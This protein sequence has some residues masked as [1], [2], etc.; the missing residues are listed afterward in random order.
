MKKVWDIYR[1]DWRRISRSSSAIFLIVALMILPSLYAWFNIKALWDPYGNTAGIKIAVANDDEGTTINNQ[2]INIGEQLVDMLKDNDSL[3]WTFVSKKEADDGVLYGDY[4]A[5]IYIPRDFTKNLSSILSDDLKK[6]E[7][8]YTY[9]DKINA[10][11]PKIT[12]KGAT[13]ITGEIS[14][15]FIRVVSEALLTVFDKMGIELNKDL[16]TIRKLEN[17]LYQLRDAIPKINA[18]GEK[19]IELEGNLPQIQEKMH[20]VLSLPDLF[21]KVNEAAQSIVKVQEAMPKIQTVGEKVT[22]LQENLPTIQ[23]VAAKVN[24]FNDNFSSVKNTLSSAIT[25]ANKASEVI[26]SL[27]VILPEMDK[28]VTN[29]EGYLDVIQ[30]FTDGVDAS[31][32]SIANAVKLNLTIANAISGSIVELTKPSDT[33]VEN[34]PINQLLAQLSSLL[35]T[36]ITHVQTLINQGISSTSLESFLQKLQHAQGNVKEAQQALANGNTEKLYTE[37]VNIQS[38]TSSILQKYDD[39]YLPAIRGVLSSLQDDLITA[40]NVVQEVQKQLPNVSDI[41]TST[42][43]IV[44]EAVTTLEKYEVALPQIEETIQ[45]ATTALN[46]N[47]DSIMNGINTGADFY[48]NHFIDLKEKVNKASDFVVTDLPGLEEKLQNAAQTIED[49]MPTVVEA[50]EIAGALA[51]NEL[52]QLTAKVSETSEK[53]EEM[54]ESVALEDVID[55]LRRDVQSDSDF[56]SNPIEL[57]EVVKFPIANYG[58]ASTPFYTALAIWV[59][60]ILLV[61][62][63]SVDV[64]MPKEMYKPHHYY[65]GRG[66]TFLTIALVQAAVVALGDIFLLKADIHD[67]WEFVLFSL[68]ICFVFTTIVYTLVSVFGNIGK[69]LA[70]ILLVLQISGSGGNFPIEVSSSFFQHIYPFLPFTYAVNLLR[71]GVGGV[72][73]LTVTKCMIVLL[74]FGTLFIVF[75]TILKKPL[76]KLVKGF[77]ENAKKSKIIH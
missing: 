35:Q 70:I 9:N 52:P 55:L 2:A 33:S 47:M 6:P 43:D 77:S 37:A 54:K 72:L 15:Q 1:I 49:K 7:I 3:G 23:N 67:R 65:F 16:P 12:S 46:E 4:Y 36:Q 26:D 58:S 75:G 19:V 63:L 71:E 22:I 66:L 61:S 69:G 76:M 62:M 44:E 68:L 17:K 42:S 32:D 50:I 30:Q 24:Q 40:D 29:S 25:Q 13:T 5:S 64:E 34:I 57:K 27:I 31:F 8:V 20:K 18:F 41:L 28:L 73:W 59:G 48:A 10:I 74:I 45:K 60:A 39:T 56:L 21:P 14:E 51:K 38:V 53:L 11:A